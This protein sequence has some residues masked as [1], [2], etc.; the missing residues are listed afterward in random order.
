MSL[1][2]FRRLT[3]RLLSVPWMHWCSICGAIR[4]VVGTQIGAWRRPFP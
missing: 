4:H 1:S 2:P 3:Y